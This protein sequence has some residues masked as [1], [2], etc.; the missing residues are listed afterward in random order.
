MKKILIIITILSFNINANQHVF[1][2]AQHNYEHH[3]NNHSKEN[4]GVV[5][6]QY[7]CPMHPEIIGK[8]KD[9]CSICGM[10]L[11]EPV[12]EDAEQHKGEDTHVCPMHTEETGKDGDR[13]PKCG[14]FLEPKKEE[15]FK[16]EHHHG[17]STNI[18]NEEQKYLSKASVIDSKSIYVCPMHPE[19]VSDKEGNCPICGMNLELKK[20][21]NESKIEIN[22]SGE[23]QQ[24]LGIRVSIAKKD[25]I[26]KKI[27]TVGE[28]GYNE[29]AVNYIYSRVDGWI[30]Y[31]NFQSIG[32]KI[33]KGDLLY[34]VYSPQ[35]VQAQKDYLLAL[36]SNTNNN[37]MIEAARLTLLLLGV[38]ESVIFQIKKERKIQ[39]NIPFYAKEK[40]VIT[41]I[42]LKKGAYINRN[43]K[44]LSFVDFD[45]FWI[46]VDLFENEQ[47]WIRENQKVFIDSRALDSKVESTIDYI[48]PEFD[49]E[50]RSLKARIIVP[51]GAF[52]PNML[53]NVEI[54]NSINKTALVI[55][56]EALIQTS[57][58]NKVVVKT[59]K[60]SFEVKEVVIGDYVNG[61][62]EI[63][64]GLEEFERVVISGQFLIDSESNIQG[65]ISRM[66]G[67]NSNA[68]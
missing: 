42:Y 39:I 34:T 5:T 20:I 2:E 1:E 19:I 55:P 46:T 68:N 17:A 36:N 22:V 45:T 61:M 24:A 14:M 16:V 48:Y 56:K 15:H 29:D 13:C 64:S 53:V 37:K 26:S 51:S 32:S 23:M 57:K 8:H 25:I 65:S 62:V 40:G 49:K 3:A 52:R 54:N 41:D 21:N 38:D 28:V 66:V 10:F 12:P 9:N 47:N 7:R 59:N 44:I 6:K 11:T 60:N 58:N 18:L 35:I 63:K 31:A 33:S 27:N 50:T 30:E 4:T 67:G 43:T